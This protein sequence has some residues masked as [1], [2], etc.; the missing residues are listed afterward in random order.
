MSVDD[1]RNRAQ[2][3]DLDIAQ[4]NAPA[5]DD[6]GGALGS[7][8]ARK[9]LRSHLQDAHDALP[10]TPPSGGGG[11]K[12]GTAPPTKE[13]VEPP[14]GGEA[15]SEAGSRSYY[16]NKVAPLQQNPSSDGERAVSQ[17]R[18]AQRFEDLRAL[19]DIT[20][21][22]RPRK[23]MRV[24]FNPQT[25]EDRKRVRLVLNDGTA[26]I[27]GLCRCGNIWACP[28]CSAKIR[29][30]R[31]DEIARAVAGHILAGG[32][33][34][35]ITLTARH[36]KYHRLDP[37]YDAVAKGWTSLIN[38][39]AWQGL[40]PT[41]KRNAVRG[42]KDLIGYVGFIR[43][44]EV[45]WG[46]RN[47]WHPHL[48]VVMLTDGTET[49]EGLMA[50]MG[51]FNSR[52]RKW[53]AKHGFEPNDEHGIRWDH[54]GTGE[55]AGEYVAKVQ[56]GKGLGNEI[57]RGDLKKG[58][59]GTL[60]PFEVLRYFRVTGDMAAVPVWR[61][62]EQATSAKKRRAITWSHGLKKRLLG[63]EEDTRT[64]Q[65]IAEEEVGGETW[66]VFPTETMT[67]IQRVPGLLPKILNAAENG[68]FPALVAI[69]T[70]WHV[71]WAKGPDAPQE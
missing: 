40:K 64:E 4:M 61:E 39:K 1:A 47:G 6:A 60:A 66:A 53:M 46:S 22:D 62:Y 21:L 52:W 45:T 49:P 31:A 68:G 15:V 48:H 2:T 8:L 14:E 12:T 71:E 3:P 65:Q 16:T 30:T 44:M 34:W 55:V 43:S 10:V 7:A 70:E 11:A 23:C 26:H 17:K 29:A 28:L 36:K 42:E 41:A 27:A 19:W 5:T 35:M 59:L 33:G 50:T 51:G 56:E 9:A 20:T 57:A 54:I 18:R 69:L 24:A 67:Q 37:L 32:N 58:R 38:T 13:G 63:D 25:G